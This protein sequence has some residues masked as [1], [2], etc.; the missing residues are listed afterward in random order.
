MAQPSLTGDDVPVKKY[1]DPNGG[2]ILTQE[3]SF[4]KVKAL[5]VCVEI[6]MERELELYSATEVTSMVT[7][8]SVGR[9]LLSASVR[10]MLM[11][12]M[13]FQSNPV[14][15]RLE[16]PNRASSDR[17]EISMRHTSIIACKEVS[18]LLLQP[19]DANCRRRAIAYIA[20][21]WDDRDS[22]DSYGVNL[23]GFNNTTR[24]IM[25]ENMLYLS[26]EVE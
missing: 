24:P 25:I 5:L 21:P 9:Q 16:C 17:P 13:A 4:D 11:R 8:A 14:L 10:D 12:I 6:E 20:C 26:V 2:L 1:F 3:L 22:E 18:K 23:M 19:T 7:D 15:C